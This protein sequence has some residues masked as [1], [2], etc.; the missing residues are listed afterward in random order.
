MNLTEVAL[1][2]A[3]FGVPVFPCNSNK[4]PCTPDGFYA[5]VT[6]PNEVV[7][8]FA[9]YPNAAMVG[10]RMGKDAGVFV[11]DVDL[12]KPGVKEWYAAQVEAGTLP[13][14]RT[15]ATKNGGLHLVYR[16]H[17][18]PTTVVTKGVDVKGEGGYVIMPGSPGYTVKLD[19]KAVTAPPALLEMCAS[20]Q[21]KTKNSGVTAL[22]AQVIRAETFHESLTVLA[23]RKA[24][25][26]MP[27]LEVQTYLGNLLDASQAARP[28]HPRHS[29]WLQLVEGTE[30]VR[31]AESAHHKYNHDAKIDEAYHDLDDD[32]LDE[33]DDITDRLFPALARM[34]IE[35]EVPE[36]EPQH[37]VFPYAGYEAHEPLDVDDV[38]F[39]MYPIFA[40]NETVVVFA[41]PKAGKTALML[42]C[43]LSLACG[44][45]FGEFQTP[46]WKPALY[47][48]LEGTRAI[49]LR[50]KGWRQH[51]EDEGHELPEKIP[52]YV[53]E[54]AP[55]FY[56]EDAKA[57]HA[58]MIE[59]HQNV[60]LTRYGKPLGLI[61]I[62][63]LTKA[64]TGGDQ[65]SAEDTAELFDI[66]RL[67]RE[68]GITATVVFVHHKNRAAGNPRGSS[69]IE[70]E[71][72]VLLDVAK[73]EP[74]VSMKIAR[75]RS[76]EDGGV[77]HY[78]LEGVDLGTN[79][80]GLSLT[81]VVPI[82]AKKVDTSVYDDVLMAIMSHDAPSISIT[83]VVTWFT[84]YGIMTKKK[85]AIRAAAPEV[86]D[87]LKAMLGDRYTT[88]AGNVSITANFNASGV[89]VS[90]TV[91][92]AT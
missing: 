27:Y 71:P 4:A 65:N 46:E 31:I 74:L 12:Y 20:Q 41:E 24:A 88:A 35:D 40:E 8:L 67:L 2:W 78:K 37:D 86:K 9:Q 25:Q 59:H 79:N 17:V 5:G 19:V 85:G 54:N 69:N 3:S 39:N 6:E 21:R 60:C 42:T 36:Y 23:A 80:Q 84:E 53:V 10:G 33:L 43:A 89:P 70:A 61:V 52:L 64:M 48:A 62:D 57:R 38:T 18:F 66:V 76:I 56:K 75:A 91:G 1:E 77:T 50:V 26:G 16:A 92:T 28:N 58:S 90:L 29:R 83:Q 82:P 68:R 14:T 51:M 22:E 72:D 13:K 34:Q 63:T 87:H 32:T 30:V 81:G 73:E 49:R 11:V 15:H 47:F 7:A 44:L 45:G 55:A